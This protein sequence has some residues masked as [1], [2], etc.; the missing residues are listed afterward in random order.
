MSQGETWDP[1]DLPETYW[2]LGTVYGYRFVM[3][4]EEGERVGK[5]LDE[6]REGDGVSGPGF[7]LARDYTG[8]PFRVLYSHVTA[9][10][11]STKSSRDFDDALKTD[12][13]K[14]GNWDED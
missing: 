2:I 3:D 11:L 7:V 6:Y 9:C 12:D 13:R 10:Y 4:L 14:R 1:E 8:A 5:L